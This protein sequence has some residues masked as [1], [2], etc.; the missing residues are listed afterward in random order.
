[1]GN[2]GEQGYKNRE[3]IKTIIMTIFIKKNRGNLEEQGFKK[4]SSR[5]G[6]S[7]EK[8]KIA[9]ATWLGNKT[10]K[11]ST[12]TKR[13]GLIIFCSVFA[14]L[15]ILLLGSSMAGHHFGNRSLIVT[16]LRSGVHDPL[17]IPIAD[18]VFEKAEKTRAW[19]DSLRKYDTLKLKAIL[20]E[21]PYLLENLEVLEN[22]YQ[23]QRK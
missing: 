12:S 22:I 11:Y 17:R 14:L 21:R 23:S 13:T 15:F 1:L 18:S 19:L 8:K 2:S 6:E 4:S 16:H 7:I 9:L 10:E 3:Q 20:L 5:L